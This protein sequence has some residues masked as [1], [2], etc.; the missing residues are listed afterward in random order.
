V[1]TFSFILACSGPGAQ[2][3][4]QSSI[5]LSYFCAAVGGVT[6]LALTY[7]S[8]REHRFRFTLPIAAILLL[9][10]PAWTVSAI[11]GDCGAMKETTSILATAVYIGLF[12]FQHCASTSR[13]RLARGLC[14]NCAYPA[15]HSIIC[16]ECG[17]DTS[18]SRRA[19][20]TLAN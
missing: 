11:Q 9:G 20:G 12:I 17:A 5:T 18:E 10:H 4:I 19:P 15:G 3:S 2:A 7:D 6:T 8:I 14:P 16:S 13:Y 1:N